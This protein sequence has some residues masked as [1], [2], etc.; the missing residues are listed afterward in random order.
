M[1]T[2]IKSLQNKLSMIEGLTV[3]LYQFFFKKKQTGVLKLCNMEYLLQSAFHVEHTLAFPSIK[4]GSRG[5]QGTWLDSQAMILPFPPRR[6][7]YNIFA[8]LLELN[9]K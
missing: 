4:G 8:F 9:A 5:Q 1:E 2:V 3:E 7:L 6:G